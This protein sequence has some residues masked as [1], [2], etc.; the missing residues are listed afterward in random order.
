MPD[1]FL[2]ILTVDGLVLPPGRI[3]PS[4]HVAFDPWAKSEKTKSKMMSHAR[5]TVQASAWNRR[6]GLSFACGGLHG[7][8]VR[9]QMKHVDQQ[10][11]NSL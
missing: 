1:I 6:L 5:G 9:C 3:K 2:K 8:R 11:N 7:T 4:Y 10:Q